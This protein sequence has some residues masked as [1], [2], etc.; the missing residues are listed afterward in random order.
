MT[1]ELKP[2]LEAIIRKRL[3]SGDFAN[4]E[5]VIERALAFLSAEEDWLA[6]N[7]EEIAAKIQQGWDSARRGELI[8]ADRAREDMA[9]KKQAWLQER[10]QA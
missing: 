7:R 1:V 2:E 4:P 8:D 3:A 9:K 6:E 10:R 5:E